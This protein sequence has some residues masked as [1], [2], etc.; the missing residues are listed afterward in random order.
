LV[1]IFPLQRA[2]AV[3]SWRRVTPAA[4]VE[5]RL[6]GRNRP[7]QLCFLSAAHDS[8]VRT[9]LDRV[10]P[11]GRRA[12]TS[13]RSSALAIQREARNSASSSLLALSRGSSCLLMIDPPVRS[14]PVI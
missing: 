4:L 6:M 14:K 5:S 3:R 12:N 8:P 10:P 11:R 13:P 9:L 1:A 2:S 7:Y